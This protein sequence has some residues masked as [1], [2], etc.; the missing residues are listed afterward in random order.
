M[1]VVPNPKGIGGF[2]AG[3]SGNPGGRS[4]SASAIQMMALRY[5]REAIELAAQIMREGKRDD[6]VRLA[7]IRE[8][9]D[10]GI[11]KPV[12]AVNLDVTLNKRLDEMSVEE[13]QEFRV[14]YAALT[15]ASPTLIDVVAEREARQNELFEDEDN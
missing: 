8:I 6:T 1:N 5:C 11:G 9:L 2:Q 15:S 10:R 13:L 7:A 14:K 4:K 12:A 3:E